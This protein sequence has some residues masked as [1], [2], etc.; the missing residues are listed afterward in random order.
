MG[1]TCLSPMILHSCFLLAVTYMLLEKS[2]FF[3]FYIDACV[4]SMIMIKVAINK[5]SPKELL[6][7]HTNA[8]MHTNPLNMLQTCSTGQLHGDSQLILF[9]YLLF[10][11]KPT[12]LSLINSMLDIEHGVLRF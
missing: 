12:A 4:L 11:N 10:V 2:F 7:R 3:S 8:I 6:S 5:F 9:S 1:A